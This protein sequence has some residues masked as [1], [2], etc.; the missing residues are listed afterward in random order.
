MDYRIKCPYCFAEFSHKDVHFRMES[1]RTPSHSYQDIEL[2]PDS[3]ERARLMEEYEAAQMFAYKDDEK[4]EAFWS[5]YEGIKT[6]RTTNSEWE[7]FGCEVYQLPVINPSSPE[8]RRVLKSNANN[9]PFIYDAD[10]MVTAVED[11]YGK[12]TRRRVCPRCHNPIPLQYGKKRTKFLS[13]IGVTGAGKTVYISQILK[14]M[15]KYASYV[16]MA[17]NFCDDHVNNFIKDNPVEINKPM[18]AS[19]QEGVLPQPMVYDLTQKNSADGNSVITD[20]IV[21]YDIAGETC[22]DPKKMVEYGDF[23]TKSDGIILLVDPSQLNIQVNYD[24]NAESKASAEPHLVLNTIHNVFTNIKSTELCDIPLAVCIPKS[25]TFEPML[26]AEAQR[27]IT[28]LVDQF[29][30]RNKPLFNA[31]EYNIIEPKIRKIIKEELL[32]ALSTRYSNYNFFV[33]SATGC[34]VVKNE[35]GR[36]CP[37]IPP[38]PKRIAEPLL[39][40]FKKFGYIK[41]DTPIRLP[42]PR[43]LPNPAVV[44]LPRTFIDKLLRRTRT[45][46]MTDAEKEAYKYELT[47]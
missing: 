8:G 19:T 13:V 43:P 30:E 38:I 21:I 36:F 42:E 35:D 4:Y 20:T 28:P 29:T 10:G 9:D 3:P 32:I 12:Q 25:D 2:M 31:T 33:F 1:I 17:S 27:D 11:I 40:M 23:V 41:A 7:K 14:Y 45:R 15:S 46:P 16:S 6:E 24:L 37:E 47:C 22:Q 39:W 18:P 34:D 44:K 26:P 5:K